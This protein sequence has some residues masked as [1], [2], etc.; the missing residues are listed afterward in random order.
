VSALVDLTGMPLGKTTLSR[1]A[2]IGLT[3]AEQVDIILDP[4]HINAELTRLAKYPVP[5]P[6]GYKLLLMVV[7]PPERLGS[8]HLADSSR[9]RIGAGGIG[10]IVL[11]HGPDAYKHDKFRGGE[12]CKIGDYVLIERYGGRQIQ[13]FGGFTL[14]FI[15]DDKIHGRMARV[16]EV[17]REGDATSDGDDAE[18][19]VA[20]SGAA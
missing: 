3:P 18:D 5:K 16:G 1:S 7:A 8:V 14:A 4:D 2:S 19:D 13:W 10:A 17:P 20:P 15:D 11:D 9:E 6:V 12:W